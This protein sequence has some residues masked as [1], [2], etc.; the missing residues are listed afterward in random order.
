MRLPTLKS[1][2]LLKSG[3]AFVLTAVVVTLFSA[4]RALE[5][6]QHAYMTSLQNLVFSTKQEI[7]AHPSDPAFAKARLDTLVQSP[8]I[9]SITLVDEHRTVIAHAGDSQTPPVNPSNFPAQGAHLIDQGALAIYIEAFAI[10][11][12]KDKV[13]TAWVIALVD[14]SALVQAESKVLRTAALILLLT[15]LVAV[16][17]SKHL[18]KYVL[19]FIEDITQT[20]EKI[21]T[22]T[23][24]VSFTQLTGEELNDLEKA[25][26]KVNEQ[27][28]RY[29]H[30]VQEEIEQTTLD[31]RETL[32]TIEVQNIELDIARK[33]AIK[34]NNSKSEFLANM[35]HEIRTPLNSIIGFSNILMRSPLNDHQADTLRAIQ[36]SSEVLLTI[37]NDILDF[38]KVEAGGIELEKKA[39]DLYTLIEDVVVMLA[40]AAHQKG[41][42]LNY[43][44]YN[45]VPR[46]IEGDELR[47][48]QV[49]TNL[50]NNA[51]KFTNQGEIVLRVMLDDS[52][53]DDCDNLKISISDTGVGLPT[54]Q[55]IDIFNAFSQADAS[56]AREFG[57]TGLGLSI[58][59][60][61]IHEMKGEIKVESELNQGSTF[62]ITLPLDQQS[63]DSSAPE[64][65]QFG[66]LTCHVVEAQTSSRKNISHILSR[67]ECNL[68]YHDDIDSV[69]RAAKNSRPAD[70][71]ALAI[72][73]LN[74]SDLQHSEIK[75]GL[76]ALQQEPMP[77]LLY[78]PTLHSYDHTALS[79]CNLHS[80]KP[81]T[82]SS[83]EH[84][85][86]SIIRPKQPTGLEAPNP[87]PTYSS[88]LTILAV[89]DN[90][91]NLKLV[92]A[93]VTEMGLQVQLASSGQQAL[94]LCKNTYYPLILMDI[95]MPNMDGPSCLSH[96]Q[97][98]SLYQSKCRVVALTAYALPSEEKAFIA[99]GFSDLLTKPLD[100]QKLGQI[101]SKHLQIS[102][103]NNSD[104]QSPKLSD[105]LVTKRDHNNASTPA[106]AIFDWQEAI[107]LCN[108]NTVLA[109]E[110]SAQM[111]A[112]LPEARTRI[113][114]A[115]KDDDLAVAESEIHSLHG[116][117][118]LCGTPA[119]RAA[120]AHAEYL[121]KRS[122]PMS[123][124]D[125]AIHKVLDE[126]STLETW[127][128]NNPL[129]A[130]DQTAEDV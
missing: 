1:N 26:N 51:V 103:N 5:Y 2:L 40:P 129:K 19:S 101:I 4:N 75:S 6:R 99:L 84:N 93:L 18:T 39:F 116:M 76:A 87:L 91:I 130:P 80:I 78:T 55:K 67:L 106:L 17:L 89:D 69:I 85:L 7:Q 47:L 25:L 14:Q 109:E 8:Q 108:D 45:D 123:E 100:E 56:T 120:V 34:A 37:I 60:G 79:L 127:R 81:V 42:E 82:A 107:H 16:F 88:A 29:R 54:S 63:L 102:P 24:Y 50:V 112:S 113:E 125:I 33:N 32:E 11:A 86:A 28:Y 9:T 66:D 90:K 104:D 48:K 97:K 114:N 118:L 119:L 64:S 41:L 12:T 53:N 3:S 30:D 59:R 27:M 13:H 20:I 115:W 117:T 73:C 124:I 43:L 57:G 92:E 122:A 65:G 15:I 111:F 96:I 62:W 22:G 110:F 61:L 71:K 68:N 121:M 126:I 52:L 94:E 105:T 46:T 70:S 58:C 77:V 35:S 95:Q 10:K 49:I 44:Y 72:I 36:K 21:Y 128:K 83:L 23:K 31:L 74:E 38:S 98:L